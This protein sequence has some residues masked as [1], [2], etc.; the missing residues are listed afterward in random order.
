MTVSN[1]EQ[2]ND[3]ILSVGMDVMQEASQ[4]AH[5]IGSAGKETPAAQQD[6]SYLK[7]A[8]N[9]VLDKQAE[10]ERQPENEQ[11]RQRER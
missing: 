7:S 1:R 3:S 4:S 9:S 8:N 6:L 2:G 10:K 11:E 5:E